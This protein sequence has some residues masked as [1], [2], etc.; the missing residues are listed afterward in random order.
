MLINMPG[1]KIVLPGDHTSVIDCECTFRFPRS[2]IQ[3]L[4]RHTICGEGECFIIEVQDTA[5]I[6]GKWVVQLLVCGVFVH[7]NLR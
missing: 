3:F 7:V 4:V 5:C 2:I 1:S 6:V